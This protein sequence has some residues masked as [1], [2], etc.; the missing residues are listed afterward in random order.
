[1]KS[2]YT[3]NRMTADNGKVCHLNLAVIDNCHL[4]NLLFRLLRIL[5]PNGFTESAVNLLHNL[6][7]S[8]KKLGEQLNGPLFQS[9]SHNGMVGVSAGF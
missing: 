8:G 2:R 6:I 3:V 1:M 7:N 9:L 5:S 4:G